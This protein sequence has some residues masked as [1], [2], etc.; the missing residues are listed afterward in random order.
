MS[1]VDLI[2]R[3]SNNPPTVS[4]MMIKN[5]TKILTLENLS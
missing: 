2:F 1:S 3:L 5:I 4:D